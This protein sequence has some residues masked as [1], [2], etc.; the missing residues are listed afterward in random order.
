MHNLEGLH[1]TL[2][3]KPLRGQ[4]MTLGDVRSGTCVCP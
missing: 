2:A 3:P 4:P 1:V